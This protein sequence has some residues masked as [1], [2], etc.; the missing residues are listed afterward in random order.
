MDFEKACAF[1][2]QW[3]LRVDRQT[4]AK[5]QP[6]LGAPQS[7]EAPSQGLLSP[8]SHGSNAKQREPANS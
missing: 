6:A 2:R 1:A 3:S 8:T 7:T 4:R 5:L